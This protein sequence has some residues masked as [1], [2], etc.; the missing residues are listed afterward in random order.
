L[1]KEKKK[2]YNLE[3]GEIQRFVVDAIGGLDDHQLLR[4]R[5]IVI[6]SAISSFPNMN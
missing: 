3:S 6:C 4:G 2:P 1:K 5:V